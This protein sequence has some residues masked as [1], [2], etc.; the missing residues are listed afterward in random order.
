MS[1]A[2]SFV[3]GLTQTW[4]YCSVVLSHG[5]KHV[6]VADDNHPVG[7]SEGAIEPGVETVNGGGIHHSSPA[8]EVSRAEEKVIQR[9]D[10]GKAID[11][12]CHNPND[13]DYNQ[14]TLLGEDLS[15]EAASLDT[16]VPIEGRQ[17]HEIDR[18]LRQ[19]GHCEGVCFADCITESPFAVDHSVDR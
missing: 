5:A 8:Q 2:L 15:V 13:G 6:P 18:H 7:D 12:Q 17:C 10:I 1:A 14:S 16:S 9:Q 4:S 3:V 11:K 19:N